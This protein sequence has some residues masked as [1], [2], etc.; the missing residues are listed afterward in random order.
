[1]VLAAGDGDRMGGLTSRIPKVLLTVLDKP[2]ILYPIEAMVRAGIR[3]IAIVIGYLG[4]KVEAFLN[5]NPVSGASLQCICN[6]NHQ[7][8]SAIS[9]EVAG[10]WMSGEPFVLCMGDHLMHRE[11]IARFLD[12]APYQETLGV[13]FIPGNHHILE[14][15]TKVLVDSA[16]LISDIGKELTRWDGIDTGVFLITESFV[17][18]VRELHASRGI[19]IEISEVIRFMLGRGQDFVTFDTTGPFWA[20]IDTVEDMR[21]VEG[22]ERWLAEKWL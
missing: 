12:K 8:G 4:D 10:E 17:D 9:V 11:Y 7:G 16:G 1:M 6:S 14:E 21:L 2:L 18:A 15:A 3:E 19:G 20:D 13:D 22:T 5:N